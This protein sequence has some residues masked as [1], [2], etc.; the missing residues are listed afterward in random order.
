VCQRVLKAVTQI[1]FDDP[2]LHAS[3]TG[4]L[5]PSPTFLKFRR[6]KVKPHFAPALVGI[7]CVV[8]GAPGLP[9]VTNIMG[10]IAVDQGR[11]I[12]TQVPDRSPIAIRE[13]TPLASSPDQPSPPI[14]S[15]EDEDE[16]AEDDDAQEWDVEA[17]GRAL[18]ASRQEKQPNGLE[19]PIIGIPPRRKRVDESERSS[20]LTLPPFAASRRSWDVLPSPALR[21][22]HTPSRSLSRAS[23]PLL[24]TTLHPDPVLQSFTLRSHYL[25]SELQFIQALEAISN[26]LLVVPKPARVSAL[27]A[28]MTSL[29]HQLPAEACIKN[30]SPVALTDGIFR[31]VFLCGATV[32]SKGTFQRTC[33]PI[34]R[35]F[36]YHPE[37]V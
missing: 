24:S 16:N 31:S 37:R 23:V 22:S 13:E 8:A 9:Q 36:A 3:R 12:D 33:N 5:L 17:Y 29:N 11:R 35:L 18:I 4:S 20:S 21:A 26:R 19:I 2:E 7:G 1:I 28:E 34:P 6:G 10:S 14:V 25:H 30:K 32:P 27:R 15:V